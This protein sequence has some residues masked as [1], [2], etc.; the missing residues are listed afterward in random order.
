MASLLVYSEKLGLHIVLKS[1]PD[2]PAAFHI[3]SVGKMFT[4][5][6]IGR[7]IDS[8]RL[9]LESRLAFWK[10]FSYSTEPITSLKLRYDS[11]WRIPRE[12]P[13]TFPAP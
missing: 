1:N 6:L 7:L 10:G 4:S 3:A 9:T 8:S 12:S 11:F 13:I 2:G 5:A